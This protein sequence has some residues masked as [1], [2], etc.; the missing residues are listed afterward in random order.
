MDGSSDIPKLAVQKLNVNNYYIWSSQLE[1][2]LRVQG[3]SGFLGRAD[4]DEGRGNAQKRDVI[5]ATVHRR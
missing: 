1:G 2:L 5:T 3:L 4:H